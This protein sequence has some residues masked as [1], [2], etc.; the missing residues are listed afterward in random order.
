MTVIRLRLKN[1]NWDGQNTDTFLCEEHMNTH[2]KW[3]EFKVPLTSMQVC[4]AK[5]LSRALLAA[6][7]N[8]AM[9][10]G[11]R[12]VD[13]KQVFQSIKTPHTRRAVAAFGLQ[14]NTAHDV[15]VFANFVLVGSAHSVAY[16]L[17]DETHADSYHFCVLASFFERYDV[18]LSPLPSLTNIPSQWVQ[19][20]LFQYLVCGLL[21]CSGSE[22]YATQLFALTAVCFGVNIR[23]LKDLHNGVPIFVLYGDRFTR[24]SCLASLVRLH[25][26]AHQPTKRASHGRLI[27][28]ARG[29][30]A[31][32]AH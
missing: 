17:V 4:G 21:R 23:I 31:N 7:Y 3:L 25:K 28:R 1:S 5:E 30:E 9:F 22:A 14:K 12:D 29:L 18:N 27:Q 6:T 15:L 11:I 24:K 8:K 2:S 32:A 10:F 20:R 13:A 26:S 19:A 16:R